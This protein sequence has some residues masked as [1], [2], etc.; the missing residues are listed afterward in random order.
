MSACEARW[1]KSA[2][3]FCQL[4]LGHAFEHRSKVRIEYENGVTGSAEITW[5]SDANL[6]SAHDVLE[7]V[8]T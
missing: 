3:V 2:E 6:R 7:T 5:V 4:E 1:I 8:H